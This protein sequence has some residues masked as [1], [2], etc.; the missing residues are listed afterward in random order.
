[1]AGYN[2]DDYDYSVSGSDN[3]S[4]VYIYNCYYDYVNVLEYSFICN[5]KGMSDDDGIAME[6]EDHNPPKDPATDCI[7]SCFSVLIT[8]II[9]FKYFRF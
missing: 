5:F 4:Q 7:V 8:L 2:D 9:F 3:E 6:Q 1:M